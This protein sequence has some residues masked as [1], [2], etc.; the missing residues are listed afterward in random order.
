MRKKLVQVATI[1]SLYIHPEDKGDLM[2]RV[3][4]LTLIEEQGIEGAPDRSYD[5][6]P[7][8]KKAGEDPN[9][10]H[11]SFGHIE[12]L[13]EYERELVAK[14][15][16]CP[17]DMTPEKFKANVILSAGF[18][19]REFLNFFGRV[20][21]FGSALAASKSLLESKAHIRFTMQRDPCREMDVNICSGAS[22]LMTRGNQGFFAR[23]IGTTTIPRRRW[24]LP[25]G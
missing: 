9:D 22:R 13:A 10:R 25:A 1:H 11:L 18:M 2:T 19:P 21:V 4:S 5:H 23:V 16:L 7:E 15:K 14:D 6:R 20:A 24:T 8:R 12:Q 3:K 17:G